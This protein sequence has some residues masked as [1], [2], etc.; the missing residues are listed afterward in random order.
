MH[1]LFRFYQEDCT[2]IADNSA[3]FRKVTSDTLRNN[4]NI[5]DLLCMNSFEIEKD[6]PRLLLEHGKRPAN[7]LWIVINE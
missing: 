6:V 2:D 5:L 7:A 1:L 3:D 4:S